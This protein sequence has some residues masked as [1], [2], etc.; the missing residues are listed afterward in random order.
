MPDSPPPTAVIAHRGASAHA[1]EN[2]LPAF[3]LALEGGADGIEFDVQLSK[4]GEVV[5][6]HDHD[7]ARTTDGRG[8]VRAAALADLKKLDAGGWFGPQFQGARIP[9]LSEALETIGRRALI[10]IELKNLASPFDEL[11]QKTAQIVS[12]L[13][14]Q[15]NVIVSSFNPLALAAF[16]GALP[17][18]PTGLLTM[19]GRPGALT[20]LLAGPFTPYDNLHPHFASVS[21][22]MVAGLRRKGGG[23]FTW[24]VNQPEDLKS[25]FALG[26]SGVITDEPA[27]GRAARAEALA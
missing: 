21:A 23:V 1:P 11:P 5:V 14:F 25:M 4:D 19:P 8:R 27:L 18:V 20:R 16:R 24:T 6:I 26:V 15:E 3:T 12:R 2:T 9:T 17:E 22:E 10:N 7:L 13:G